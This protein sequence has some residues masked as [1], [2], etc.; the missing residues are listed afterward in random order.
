MKIAVQRVKI[1]CENGT[2]AEMLSKMLWNSSRDVLK[3]NNFS[4]RI[5]PTPSFSLE[6]YIDEHI[7]TT[8]KLALL[9]NGITKSLYTFA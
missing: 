2:L 8:V 1:A 7:L 5:S 3:L 9:C 6:T 4:G